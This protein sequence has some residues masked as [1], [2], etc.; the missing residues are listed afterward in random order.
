[1]NK[2]RMEKNNIVVTDSKKIRNK[3]FIYL[4]TFIFIALIIIILSNKFIIQNSKSVHEKNIILI[5]KIENLESEI[6]D[7]EKIIDDLVK[8]NQEI[9]SIFNKYTDAIK[10]KVA[11]SEEIRDELFKKD[12]EILALNREI[13]YYK[14]LINSKDRKN[15]LSIEN[16]KLDF[17]EEN[18]I[19]YYSF[20][21][22]SNY[23]NKKITGSFN[24]FY[25]G[26]YLKNGKLFKKKK[27]SLK[28]NRINFKN[29]LQLSGAITIPDDQNIKTLYIDV[30]CNGK[31]YNYIYTLN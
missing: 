29:Y 8:K 12:E 9:N 18:K 16:V 19:L 7:K 27:M 11:T 25:D 5:S 30:K 31:L 1:M 22:L 26:N 6:L 2:N 3:L 14:F 28:N 20:L 21:L 4:I 10:F 24:L 13:N 23:N 15:I 17:E